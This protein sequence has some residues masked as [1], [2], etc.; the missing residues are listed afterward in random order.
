MIDIKTLLI[1]IN[2]IITLDIE[3]CFK[4][5]S[6]SALFLIPNSDEII[7]F[8]HIFALCQK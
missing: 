7:R 6:R 8:I 2:N 1:N 3:I 4:S 5:S